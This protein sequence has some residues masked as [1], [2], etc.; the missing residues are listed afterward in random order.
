[1]A[2]TLDVRVLL[3]SIS[4]FKDPKKTLMTTTMTCYLVSLVLVTFIVIERNFI[5]ILSLPKTP[6]HILFWVSLNRSLSQAFPLLA[7]L[8]KLIFC[9]GLENVLAMLGVC[10]AAVVPEG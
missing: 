3:V 10:V 6:V 1:M 8:V 7:K 9:R 2:R 5:C 4:L